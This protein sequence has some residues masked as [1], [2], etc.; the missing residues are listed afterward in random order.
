VAFYAAAMAASP[1]R[2][3]PLALRPRPAPDRAGAPA[4]AG[5]LAVPEPAL[6]VPHR[7]PWVPP[8]RP[9]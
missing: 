8:R 4:A 2:R 9:S 3:A 1:R 6:Q 5:G 7:D